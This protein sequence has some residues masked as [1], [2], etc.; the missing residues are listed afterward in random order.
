MAD[1]EGLTI[2]DFAKMI[3]DMSETEIRRYLI[4]FYSAHH[5]EDFKELF[6]VFSSEESSLESSSEESGLE[7]SPEDEKVSGGRIPEPE[8]FCLQQTELTER[9]KPTL[10]VQ[11]SEESDQ[12]DCN[13]KEMTCDEPMFKTIF[14]EIFDDSDDER[15]KPP[16]KKKSDAAKIHVDSNAAIDKYTKLNK[17]MNAIFEETLNF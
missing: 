15:R 8:I 17:R 1:T 14:D 2:E 16:P 12:P 11:S 5:N 13:V 9:Q 3:T 6:K 4:S 7:S 10:D